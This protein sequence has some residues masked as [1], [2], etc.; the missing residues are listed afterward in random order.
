M[1]TED[2]AITGEGSLPEVSMEN[3]ESLAGD[4]TQILKDVTVEQ[5][6]AA[7]QFALEFL[8]EVL[9]LRGVRI[10][11]AQF[12]KAELHK[13]GVGPEVLERAIA[14]T[15][16][17]AGI[18]L[19]MLD[20][21]AV[22]SIRFETQKSSAISFAAGLPGGF[23]MLGTIPGDITQFYVHAF[24][25]MQKL[26]YVYGWQ[27]LLEDAKDVD[28]ETLGVLASL[29]GVMMGVGAASGAVTTFAANVARPAVQKQITKVALTKTAWY[30]PMKQV[31]KI[32]GVK[33]TK[34]TFANAVAKVVPVVGGV[35]SGSMT[36][37]TLDSQSKRLMRHL[38][39]IPP[40]NV[41]ADVYL[42]ALR[43]LDEDPTE[44]LGGKVG[45]VATGAVGLFRPVDRDGDGVPDE[46]QAVEG[47]KGAASAVRKRFG[48]VRGRIRPRSGEGEDPAQSTAPTNDEHGTGS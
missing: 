43:A 48:W 26:A 14:E 9:R 8:K 1:G 37:I 22:S 36:M 25:V 46:S 12:L 11:R 28:D 2:T 3:D 39:E 27:A 33:I 19:S 34:Q 21:I 4:P 17:A 16:V 13:R 40:P 20:H 42:E 10:D 23:A 32:V 31:L 6:K 45:A 18:S 5:Q 41:A 15:P 47:V 7:E 44:S 35:V 24:R 38:R 30:T 29:L